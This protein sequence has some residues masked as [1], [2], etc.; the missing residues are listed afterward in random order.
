MIC[1]SYISDQTY[2]IIGP[3]DCSCAQEQ[4]DSEYVQNEQQTITSAYD[5]RM[6]VAHS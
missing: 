5:R 3:Y 2:A 6:K 1:M 4:T